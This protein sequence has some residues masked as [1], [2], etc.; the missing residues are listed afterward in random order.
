MATKK[1][2]IKLELKIFSPDGETV[3]EK[4]VK[5]ALLKASRDEELIRKITHAHASV[6]ATL[7]L[8][9]KRNGAG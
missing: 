7:A 6:S 9:I 5:A 1:G 8:P 3:T 2:P 4:A